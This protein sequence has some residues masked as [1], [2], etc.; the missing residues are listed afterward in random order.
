M[1]APRFV[2]GHGAAL[3]SRDQG[4]RSMAAPLCIAFEDEEYGFLSRDAKEAVDTWLS[5]SVYHADDA[6]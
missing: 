3:L 5:Y 6:L 1:R 2:T 4:A